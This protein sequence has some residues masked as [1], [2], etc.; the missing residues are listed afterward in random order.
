MHLILALGNC[1]SSLFQ[2]TLLKFLL[3]M[4]N[5]QPPPESD[6]WLVSCK[7]FNLWRRY[8]FEPRNRAY[9]RGTVFMI[10][11]L[12]LSG[13]TMYTIQHA[14]GSSALYGRRSFRRLT[15]MPQPHIFTNHCDSAMMPGAV[16]V[17]LDGISSRV[18]QVR[19]LPG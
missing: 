18:H 12:I 16:S 17:Y 19:Y 11:I 14:L 1:K 8:P 7:W 9:I 6:S 2:Y 15:N 13:F 5:T 4:P 10:A 3:G